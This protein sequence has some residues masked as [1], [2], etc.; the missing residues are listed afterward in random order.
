MRLRIYNAFQPMRSLDFARPETLEFGYLG[1]QLLGESWSSPMSNGIHHKKL[2][3]CRELR[4]R[5]VAQ[6]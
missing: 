5:R 2:H 6:D 3:T 4:V 1:G